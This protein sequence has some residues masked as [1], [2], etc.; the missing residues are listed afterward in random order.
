MPQEDKAA[1]MK[2]ANI[3]S[4]D[5]GNVEMAARLIFT[6]AALCD[7]WSVRVVDNIVTSL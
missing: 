1:A 2:G 6:V 4:M 5:M 3:L 7:I